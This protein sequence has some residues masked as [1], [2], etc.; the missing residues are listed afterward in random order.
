MPLPPYVFAIFID[1]NASE[2]LL[3]KPNLQ[4]LIQVRLNPIVAASLSGKVNSS[5]EA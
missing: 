1:L 2:Y 5:S 4:M 3:K